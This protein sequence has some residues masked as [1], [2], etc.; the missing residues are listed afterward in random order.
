MVMWGEITRKYES[1]GKHVIPIPNRNSIRR[2]P[3]D[4]SSRKALYLGGPTID[5]HAEIEEGKSSQ[6]ENQA[7]DFNMFGGSA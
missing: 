1:R 6:P 4:N 7:H 2:R 5:S 3:L